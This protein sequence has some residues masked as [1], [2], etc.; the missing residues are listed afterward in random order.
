VY[1]QKRTTL[2]IPKLCADKKL[3]RICQTSLYSKLLVVN[4]LLLGIVS[5]CTL[6][7]QKRLWV[8]GPKATTHNLRDHQA[9][10]NTSQDRPPKSYLS[11]TVY[12][13]ALGKGDLVTVC[14]LSGERSSYSLY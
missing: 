13:I 2:C 9:Y 7:N 12:L 6:S 14:S 3:V 10:W 8:V 1:V 4:Y 5:G 11:P